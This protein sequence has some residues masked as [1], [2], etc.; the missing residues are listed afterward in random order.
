MFIVPNHEKK[1]NYYVNLCF[2]LIDRWTLILKVIERKDFLWNQSITII[3][4]NK[5]NVF[6]GAQSWQKLDYYV[7]L[8]LTK[9]MDEH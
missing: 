2:V 6:I 7:N 1:G 4:P 3:Y 8:C 9:S 5:E